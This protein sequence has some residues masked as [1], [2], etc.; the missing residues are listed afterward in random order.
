[1]LVK[2]SGMRRDPRT[3]PQL[4][5]YFERM[6]GRRAD[7]RPVVGLS[8]G[9]RWE[10]NIMV[11]MQKVL[12][13]TLFTPKGIHYW[14]IIDPRIQIP[15]ASRPSATGKAASRRSPVPLPRRCDEIPRKLHP[16]APVRLPP[17]ERKPITLPRSGRQLSM[18]TIRKIALI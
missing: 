9:R 6:R 7:R 3:S 16:V 15:S 13:I 2:I 4:R 17:L 10:L 1:L 5:R 14:M 11:E 12:G 18:H 8:Q